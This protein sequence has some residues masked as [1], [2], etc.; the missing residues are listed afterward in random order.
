MMTRHEWE[1]Y[2]SSR[3]PEDRTTLLFQ[4]AKRLIEIDEVGFRMDGELDHDTE[5]IE[6]QECFFWLGS[7][8]NVLKGRQP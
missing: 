1:K 2:L 5:D 3:S 6:D 7:G 4:F 8:E